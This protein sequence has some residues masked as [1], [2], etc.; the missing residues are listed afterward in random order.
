MPAATPQTSPLRRLSK[1]RTDRR[2]RIGR[3]GTSTDQSIPF[4]GST[5]RADGD[6]FLISTSDGLDH[7]FVSK[8]AYDA[9]VALEK[10]GSPTV[11][12]ELFKP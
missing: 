12:S 2:S 9:A 3:V 6:Q 8:E 7:E 4:E 10:Y 1:F 11:P 5:F